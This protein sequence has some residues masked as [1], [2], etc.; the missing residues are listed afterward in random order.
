MTKIDYCVT[1]TTTKTKQEAKRIA[2]AMLEAK[3]AACVQ[4]MPI[5]SHYIWKGEVTDSSEIL[6]LIKTRKNLFS[7]IQTLISKIHSY[8][9]PELIQ[10]DI[11]A[12]LPE[13]L[14]WIQDNT[15]HS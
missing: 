6:L 8:E 14:N 1:V 10:L 12:G 3:L 2:A 13:Y 15:K 11:G 7:D 9:T 5:E 4:L